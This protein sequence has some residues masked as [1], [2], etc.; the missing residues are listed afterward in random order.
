MGQNAIFSAMVAFRLL[1]Y[2]PMGEVPCLPL[3]SPLGGIPNPRL[4]PVPPSSPWSAFT[5][6]D[7]TPPRSL[8]S[9]PSPPRSHCRIVSPTVPL[10]Y[11]S[12]PG[13]ALLLPSLP[14]PSQSFPTTSAPS[15]GSVTPL[16]NRCYYRQLSALG[17]GRPP[18]VAG[19]LHLYG[20]RPYLP[21]SSGV[22][23][24]VGV[25]VPLPDCSSQIHSDRCSASHLGLGA[26]SALSH[27]GN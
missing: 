11:T 10:H 18:T 15:S 21:W 24:R 5:S 1:I 20:K 6:G 19:P 3:P 7:G 25:A 13:P 2:S 26:C 4:P 8:A 27:A 17:K 22:G 9:P 14:A 16:P 12:S 23:F